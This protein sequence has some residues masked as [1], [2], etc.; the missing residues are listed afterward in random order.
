MA[1]LLIPET[2]ELLE[3]LAQTG[4]DFSLFER[5]DPL[6]VV[7]HAL[8]SLEGT[9]CPLAHRVTPGLYTRTIAMPAGAWVVSKI[10]KTHHQFLIT[11]GRV[12]VWM[13]DTGWRELEAIHHGET[14]PGTRRLLRVM[15]NTVWTTF[16][17]IP[18]VGP[19]FVDLHFIEDRLIQPRTILLQ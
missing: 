13:Q 15:E 7:Q 12:R 5:N 6:D 9:D 2:G 17:P 19:D 3:L 14:F 16:H 1:A 4:L 10:H 11:E 8:E 18:E